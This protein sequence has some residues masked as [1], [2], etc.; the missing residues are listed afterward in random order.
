MSVIKIT[1]ERAVNFWNGLDR[2]GGFQL[3]RDCLTLLG[4]N[5]DCICTKRCDHFPRILSCD[6]GEF[7]FVLSDCG[8]SLDVYRRMVR[9]KAIRPIFITDMEKQ[10]D[11]IVDNLKKC[12]VRHLDMH[13]T[14]KNICVSDK[15][16]ISIIDFDIASIG[17]DFRSEKLAER[18]G[19]VGS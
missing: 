11:C 9:E 8:Y 12:G 3:E 5:F 16:I 6:P 1:K 15:G 14:G 4:S 2:D 10:V 19:G 7:K 17:N 13:H 18:G